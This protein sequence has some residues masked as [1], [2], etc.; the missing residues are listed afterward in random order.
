MSVCTV[1]NVSLV[2]VMMTS[3]CVLLSPV[4]FLFFCFLFPGTPSLPD[5]VLNV[6]VF[7]C[8]TSFLFASLC[9]LVKLL[10]SL[11]Y[12]LKQVH[13]WFSRPVHQNISVDFYPPPPSA[14]S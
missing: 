7:Y 3:T 2:L 5:T 14:P 4:L 12:K 6:S 8:L 1:V 9:L 10:K 13:V 11:P